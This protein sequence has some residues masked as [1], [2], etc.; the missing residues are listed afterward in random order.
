VREGG[1][2]DAIPRLQLAQRLDPGMALYPRQLG[3][4]Q[5]LTGDAAEATHSLNAA[6]ALNPSDDLAWRILALAEAASDD[7]ESARLAA[8]QA[9]DRQRSD[10]TN[11]LLWARWQERNGNHDDAVATLAEIVQAWP[12]VVA[13]PGWA[14]LLPAG[15]STTDLI[16]LAIDW[17]SEE[18]PSPET[19]SLQPML[20]AVMA[21]RADAVRAMAE[22]DLGAPLGAA[23]LAVMSCDP[24]AASLLDQA[25]DQA[26]RS[27]LYW[28]LVVRQARLDGQVDASADRLFEIMTSASLS[29][30]TAQTLNP[31]RENGLGGFS[32]DDWGYRRSPIGWPDYEELPSPQAGAARWLVEPRESVH[33]AGLVHTLTGCR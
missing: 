7:A 2:E 3:T 30:L 23:Y 16:E 21:G 12:E 4:A 24:S 33:H 5:L 26:R 28:S 6:V 31:L 25:P 9:V 19:R 22:R 13:A 14:D 20:L 8:A 15:V 10:A 1:L 17:W 32:A 27:W 11:L 29:A 18:R